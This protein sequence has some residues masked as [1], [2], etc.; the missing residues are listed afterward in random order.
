MVK[1]R[2]NRRA[3]PAQAEASDTPP[4]SRAFCFFFLF[5]VVLPFALA[6]RDEAPVD[7]DRAFQEADVLLGAG[8]IREGLDRM[9]E[10]VEAHPEDASIQMRYGQALISAGQPS[11]A[12]W[13]L[14]RAFRQPDHVISA[15]LLLARAQMW[16]GS[17]IDAVKT[18]TRVLEADPKNEAAL[19]IRVEAHLSERVEERALEDLELLAA[20]TKNPDSVEFLRL[21]ALLGIGQADE[22]A[23]LLE[24]LHDRATEMKD[25]DPA[26]AARL[27]AAT[28]T[29][30]H[31]RGDQGEAKLRFEDCLE[32]FGTSYGVLTQAAIDFFDATKDRARATEIYA[33]QFEAN[34]NRLDT[35]VRYAERLRTTGKGEEG[36]ALLLE[37]A[38]QRPRAWAA[39]ADFYAIEGDLPKAVDALDRVMEANPSQ[40][41]DWRF[42]RA[43][44]LLAMGEVDRVEAE[45]DSFEVPAHR[46]LIGGRVALAKGQ[47]DSA[48]E[49]FEEGTRLWPDNPDARFLA[50][51][52]YE[53][54]GSWSKA[55]AHYREAARMQDP[56]YESSIALAELQNALGDRE[57]VQFLLARLAEKRP[58]DL[59]VLERLLEFAWDTG[60]TEMGGRFLSKLSRIPGQAAH[61]ASLVARRIERAEGAESALATVERAALDLSA[62]KHRELLEVKVDLL[63]ELGRIADAK[64]LIEKAAQVHGE[65]V[66]LLRLTARV[67]QAE[68]NPDAA[69]ASLR[70]ALDRDETNFEAL[71]ALAAAEAE[72]KNAESARALYERAIEVERV[73]DR[74][75]IWNEGKASVALARFDF[76][77]N[78]IE[79]GR[80]RLRALLEENPR[81]GEAA[82]LLLQSYDGGRGLD[83]EARIDLAL[84]ASVFGRIKEAAERLSELSAT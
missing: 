68:G 48:A 9:R 6:C 1:V 67:A 64:T 69:I 24:E 50:A 59:D 61:A 2:R 14:S 84:R 76:S 82:W 45:L 77:Q 46:A 17:G 63:L 51:Q 49:Q 39:L 20:I 44:F 73:A 32:E 25:V 71:M 23:V 74:K 26:S 15:G 43:D 80:R 18:A 81:Q 53:R 22:A 10:A 27:C 30:R 52:V 21:D 79:G 4:V 57:G 40:R 37:V 38:E 12:V 66:D 65:R 28:A 36:E 75:R 70:A 47:L 72:Q 13:P 11:L 35:R 62:P 58:N 41:E 29:F 83:R 60:A 16:G 54:K 33:G 78:D 5:I 34:P 19:M 8:K 7:V 56:H 3:W 31:E 55:A 42:S